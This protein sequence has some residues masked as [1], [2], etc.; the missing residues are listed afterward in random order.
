MWH[1]IVIFAH[2]QDVGASYGVGDDNYKRYCVNNIP[3]PLHT[4]LKL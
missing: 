2:Y 3:S 4:Y 1:L